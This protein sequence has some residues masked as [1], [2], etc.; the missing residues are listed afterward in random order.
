MIEAGVRDR[1]HE[2]KV[3]CRSV[4]QPIT[5]QRHRKR[6]IAATEIVDTSA[7]LTHYTVDPITHDADEAKRTQLEQVQPLDLPTLLP[8]EGEI[9][10]FYSDKVSESNVVDYSENGLSMLI[11]LRDF[12]VV[13]KVRG[14]MDKTKIRKCYDLWAKMQRNAQST[15]L[16]GFTRGC[17]EKVLT[18]FADLF[19]DRR[20]LQ[21]EALLPPKE[22]AGVSNEAGEIA[23][24]ESKAF[25][26]R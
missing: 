7:T 4:E 8:D 24:N 12:G 22:E 23:R 1:V 15:A 10:F 9:C 13:Y 18:A 14:F 6:L 11:L 25:V 17:F 2:E 19:F 20:L 26:E 3:E 5:I 21:L 16:E